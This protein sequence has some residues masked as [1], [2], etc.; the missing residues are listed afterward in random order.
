M[1]R[2][3]ASAVRLAGCRPSTMDSTIFGARKARRIKRKADI[4]VAQQLKAAK[5]PGPA[6]AASPQ[7]RNPVKHSRRPTR[8]R[9]LGSYARVLNQARIPVSPLL[10]RA[11]AQWRAVTE[12]SFSGDEL[13]G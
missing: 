8:P 10:A 12:Q 13:R 4:L 9:P 3:S 5:Q 2:V 1:C 7:A 6:L 11:V